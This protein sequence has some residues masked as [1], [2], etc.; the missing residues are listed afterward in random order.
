M[1]AHGSPRQS[2]RY[3]V[4]ALRALMIAGGVSAFGLV[5]DFVVLV[6]TTALLVI[7]ALVRVPE[8][9]RLEPLTPSQRAQT[10]SLTLDGCYFRGCTRTPSR[11]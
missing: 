4:D 6:G 7:V 1:A 10:P 8:G 11:T 2:A 3:E 9:G 5:T